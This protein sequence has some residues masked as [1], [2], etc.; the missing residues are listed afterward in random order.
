MYSLLKLEKSAI[1][2]LGII[3][4]ITIHAFKKSSYFGFLIFVKFNKNF[5]CSNTQEHEQQVFY[6]TC[7]CISTCMVYM[8]A[9]M[10][11][12]NWQN[13]HVHVGM[14]LSEI[15]TKAFQQLVL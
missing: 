14:Y 11:K 9:L 2:I 6:C 5:L 4:K 15:G 12:D 10:D 1:L 8:D 7:T 13:L 3:N